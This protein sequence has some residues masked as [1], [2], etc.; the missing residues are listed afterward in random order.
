[1]FVIITDVGLLVIFLKLCKLDRLQRNYSFHALVTRLMTSCKQKK[2]LFVLV[3]FLFI[4]VLTY[5]N[6]DCFNCRA[7]NTA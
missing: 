4:F 6:C 5:Y 3:M 7:G 1:M 2:S